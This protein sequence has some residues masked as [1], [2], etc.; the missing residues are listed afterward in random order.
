MNF[1]VHTF[2]IVFMDHNKI[3]TLY[4]ITCCWCYLE[5]N[6]VATIVATNNMFSMLNSKYLDIFQPAILRHKNQKKKSW[7]ILLCTNCL[8]VESQTHL[9]A[10]MFVNC[11]FMV[12]IFIA[13]EYNFITG[14]KYKTHKVLKTGYLTLNVFVR[15]RLS[16]QPAD[17][18]CKKKSY[19]FIVKKQWS[20]NFCFKLTIFF[21]FCFQRKFL[22]KN[23]Q[24]CS[25]L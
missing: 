12:S 17:H 18:D 22:R 8:T 23:K 5:W 11:T 2:F 4:S 16:Q 24:N 10:I 13:R 3:R 19:K 20:D 7:K 21:L 1:V 9:V 15:F 6:R 14:I 25:Y